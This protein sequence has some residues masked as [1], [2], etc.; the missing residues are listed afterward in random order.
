MVNTKLQISNIFTDNHGRGV[1]VTHFAVRDSN[2]AN[3][4][5]PQERTNDNE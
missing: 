1:S 3:S 2:V 4:N 5:C